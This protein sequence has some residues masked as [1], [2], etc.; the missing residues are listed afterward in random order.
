MEKYNFHNNLNK[1][2][3]RRIGKSLSDINKKLLKESL[4]E[5]LYSAENL[6][7]SPFKKKYLE[8]GFGMGEHFISQV[9]SNPESLYIGVEVYLNGV[10]NLLKQMPYY[11]RDNFMIWPDDIDLI[12]DNIPGS[13]FDGIYILFP[14][15]W[16]KRRHLKKRLLNGERLKIIANKLKPGGFLSFASDID[17]YFASVLKL[18]EANNSFE[19]KT[20]DPTIPHKGYS[21][22]KYHKKA[23]KEGRIPQF[24]TA[25]VN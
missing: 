2:F 25:T 24:L 20:A 11:E 21:E 1:T 14:D 8:I 17:D 7:Y 10:A 19:I 15:P 13:T 5:Y 12:L 22:T 16:H 6:T 18:L 9:N 4:P 23:L 3:A